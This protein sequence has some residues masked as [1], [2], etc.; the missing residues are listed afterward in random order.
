MNQDIV[1]QYLGET[2]GVNSQ[3]VVDGL[4]LFAVGTGL[5]DYLV[6]KQRSKIFQHNIFITTESGGHRS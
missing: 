2:V 1:D 6:S 3:E 5:S 4:N